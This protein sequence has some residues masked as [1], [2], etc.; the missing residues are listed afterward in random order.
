MKQQNP[1]A[2]IAVGA[3]MLVVG[4]MVG[5]FGRPLVAQQT[6]EYAARQP[7]PTAEEAAEAADTAAADAAAEDEEPAAD[8]AAEDEEPTA[9]AAPEDVIPVAPTVAVPTADAAAEDEIPVAP[10]VAVPTEGEMDD[11][12]SALVAQTRHFKGEPDAPV[13]IIEFSDFRC[14]FCDVFADEA[15]QQI[16]TTYIDE[17]LVRLGYHHAAYQGEQ[18]LW[19]A[20]ASECAAAQDAFWLYHDYLFEVAGERDFSRDNLKAFAG[21][22]DL[23]T[24]AFDSCMESGEYA[25]VVLGETARAQTIGV[26]GTPSFLIN[27]EPLVGAQPYANFE[28]VIEAE[29]A[30]AESTGTDDA[31]TDDTDTD[32]TDTDTDDT[33]DTDTDDTD[34]DDTDTD[35]TDDE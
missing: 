9:D 12:M 29:L 6:M 32:D 22:L 14:H 30:A 3:L 19:A 10:T 16:D 15:G 27:G 4:I 20:E 5:Y 13:T 25:E 23:D 31:D 2:L 34:T 35:D 11:L 33:D 28:R 7:V 24:D 17:G 21:E 1:L 18:S 8:A 26:R